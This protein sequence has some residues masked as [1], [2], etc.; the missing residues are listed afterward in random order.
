MRSERVGTPGPTS[1]RCSRTPSAGAEPLYCR[2][3]RRAVASG[4]DRPAPLP[5]VSC[6]APLITKQTL[7]DASR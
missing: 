2:P 4:Y 7:P 5:T 3:R 1:N 6:V